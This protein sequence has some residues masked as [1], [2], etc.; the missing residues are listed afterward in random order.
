MNPTR[1]HSICR[2]SVLA[3]LAGALVSTCAMAQFQVDFIAKI[4]PSNA[5]DEDHWGLACAVMGDF[6]LMT[7]ADRRF[8][9]SAA[10]FVR[11]PD[12]RWIEVHQFAPDLGD[13]DPGDCVVTDQFLAIG[14]PFD[15]PGSKRG[16]VYTYSPLPPYEQLAVLA[17][18]SLSHDA[19]FGWAMAGEGNTLV[20]GAPGGSAQ[21]PGQLFAFTLTDTVWIEQSLELMD[22]DI[23]YGLY[24]DIR[25]EWLVV[26]G[27]AVRVFRREGNLFQR[28]P[29]RL[30]GNGGVAVDGDWLLAGDQLD[31]TRGLGA[32]AATLYKFERGTWT[33]RQR[34]VPTGLVERG[35]FGR[36]VAM[37]RGSAVVAA[38]G[39][40]DPDD[41]FPGRVYVF[42]YDTFSDL[43]VECGV[44][45]PD[46]NQT[47]R[48]GHDVSMDAGRLAIGHPY[49]N[50]GGGSEDDQGGTSVFQVNCHFLEL[51]ASP[52]L[53]G[54]RGSLTSSG[55]TPGSEVMFVMGFETGLSVVDGQFGFYSTFLIDGIDRFRVIG[56]RVF[57][58]DGNGIASV[59]F[60]VPRWTKGL[61]VYFQAAERNT[62]PYE[63]TSDRIFVRVE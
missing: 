37:R 14:A 8:D 57:P 25:G 1:Q 63:R 55:A 48:F 3:L 28:D 6:L 52:M 33:E 62:Q 30:A 35:Y 22:P 58:V 46:A 34:L 13:F 4:L 15:R 40:G 23:Q 5:S 9:G 19:A 2:R 56:N 36:Q 17:P 45:I 61:P 29:M 31:E 7:S 41:D 27:E 38:P 53:A 44:I 43:W 18:E 24:V 47:G 12:G 20:V 21:K 16:E 60:D 59:E 49:S 32:G 54:E 50:V 10:A 51:T 11:E 26:S 39:L 42:E